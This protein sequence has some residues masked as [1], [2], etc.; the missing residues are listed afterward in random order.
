MSGEDLKA[1]T[2]E[3]F[4][5]MFN[6]GDLTYVEQ[7]HVP[8]AVDHQEP[9]GTDFTDHLKDVITKMR[10]AFPDLH[11]EVDDI[12]Q[13]GDIV[14]TRSTMTG[15][16][17]GRFAMGPLEAI[18]PRGAKVSVRHMHFF[19]YENGRVKD[20]WHVWDTLGLMRQLGAPAPDMR[21][22]VPQPAGAA[23]KRPPR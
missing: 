10:A 19:Q 9:L 7:A 6:Q 16:H 2:L 4:E 22:P 11:F 13:E 21:F 8:A 17:L 1:R 14:A 20:L 5:R 18:E 15:T 3:G 12:V 23:A